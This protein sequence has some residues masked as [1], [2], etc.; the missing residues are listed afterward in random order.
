MTVPSQFFTPFATE[1]S[2]ISRSNPAIVTTSLDNGYDANL[3]IRI[4]LPSAAFGMSE[5]NGKVYQ[6]TP[7]TS[8]TFSIGVDS[9]NFEP[10]IIP[11]VIPNLATQVPQA[12]PISESGYQFQEAVIND[13]TSKPTSNWTNTTFPWVNNPNYVSP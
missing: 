3:F 4:V 2:G 1:I 7:I 13:G 10:F 11:P 5:V 9:T 12:I 6:V 8:N